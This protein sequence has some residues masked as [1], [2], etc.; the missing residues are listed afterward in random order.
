MA[1]TTRKSVSLTLQGLAERA[2]PAVL[3]NGN[4]YITGTPFNDA[5]EVRH[6]VVGETNMIE[7]EQTGA[8]VQQFLAAR[9]HLVKIWGLDGDDTITAHIGKDVVAIGGGGDDVITTGGGNDRLYGGNGYDVLV[10]GAGNDGLWG[11]NG[12]DWLEGG[13]G[14][15]RLYGEKGNDVLDGGRG[16]DVIHAGAG[17]DVGFG[18]LGNDVFYGL[19]RDVG[20]LSAP[21]STPS[22]TTYVFGIQDANVNAGDVDRI[23]N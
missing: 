18:G 12:N 19:K 13:A 20:G 7:V 1:A 9:V 16:N 17:N 21:V 3:A 10:S 14:N 6:V 23:R 2:V 22:G 5:I 15:D 4:L 8:A 11:G